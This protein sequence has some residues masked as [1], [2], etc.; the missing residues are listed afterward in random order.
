M[1]NVLVG[2]CIGDALGMPFETRQP[3]DPFL[4]NWDGKS[5][6]SSPH[7]KLSSGQFTDD[8]QMMQMVA[9]SLVEKRRFVPQDLAAKYVNWI[10]SGA[11]RGYGRTTLLA[12]NNLQAGKSYAESGVPGSYGNGTAMRAAPFGVFFR[13]DIDALMDVVKIDSAIT[14]K[15]PEAEAGALA[16]ALAT[17]FIG[18]EDTNEM[19]RR[20]VELLPQSDVRTRLGKVMSMVESKVKP[21]NVLKLIGTRADVRQ[22]VPAVFYLYFK[23]PNYQD[24]VE[25][26]IRAGGDTDTTAAIVGALIGAR[27]GLK[28]IPS[29]YVDAVEDRDKLILLDSQ[30]Q[31]RNNKNYFISTGGV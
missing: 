1:S 4:L 13:H 11:A 24:A 15:S 5:F 29:A 26:A 27:D 12:I 25:H 7:H 14:H 21:L 30:L 28:G 22:T 2:G 19:I 18:N 23:F 9:E 3:D 31:T 16:I 20:I 6:L 17:Y 8:G 10:E